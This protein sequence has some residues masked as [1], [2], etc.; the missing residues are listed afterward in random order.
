METQTQ[1]PQSVG[2]SSVASPMVQPAALPAPA[3]KPRSTPEQRAAWK[4]KYRLRRDRLAG[5]KTGAPTGAPLPPA[6]S[7]PD[8]VAAAAPA[9][10]RVLWSGGMLSSLTGRIIDSVEENTLDSLK[11]EAAKVP[12]I[13]SA[14][15]ARVE[16]DGPW[17]NVPKTTL[18]ET[19][20]EVVAKWLNHFNI[21]AENAPE[22][23]LC[24]A[25]GAIWASH[26]R[27]ASSLKKLA[28]EHAVKSDAPGAANA[29][30]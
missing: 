22:V 23:L 26:A 18:K 8:P 11:E 5:A 19:T 2:Q 17:D 1:N 28:A 16:K 10:P 13:G 21:G 27:L 20:P 3:Q 7:S 12:G 4:E 14:L 29:P 25:L 9:L 24:T 6:E 15:V 30:A